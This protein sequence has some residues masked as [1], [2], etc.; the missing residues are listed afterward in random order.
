MIITAEQAR[1]NAEQAWLLFLN[2]AHEE[3][4]KAAHGGG[5]WVKVTCPEKF[6]E[7]VIARLKELGFE[8]EGY[9]ARPRSLQAA[10]IS[11]RW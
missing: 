9:T 11:V 7:K 6:H 3:I 4:A 10:S 2:R 8:A 1:E 5:R